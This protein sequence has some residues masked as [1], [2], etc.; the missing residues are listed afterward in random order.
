LQT[1]AG[2]AGNGFV[3]LVNVERFLS[4]CVK[5]PED[6]LDVV[7]HLLKFMFA[8]KESATCL[9]MLL[10]DMEQKSA[11]HK[12]DRANGQEQD[13]QQRGRDFEPLDLGPKYDERQDYSDGGRDYRECPPRAAWHRLGRWLR[14]QRAN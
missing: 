13:E 12:D 10:V 1:L 7:G 14:A 8:G 2:T 9:A 3:S 5:L 6:F 4:F 11:V